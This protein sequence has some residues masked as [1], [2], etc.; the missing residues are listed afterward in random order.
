MQEKCYFLISTAFRFLI[1]LQTFIWTLVLACMGGQNGN[2]QARVDLIHWWTGNSSVV[3]PSN[4]H[5]HVQHSCTR[6]S[7]WECLP[8]VCVLLVCSHHWLSNREEQYENSTAMQYSMPCIFSLLW[9]TAVGLY[10]YIYIYHKL[11]PS[12]LANGTRTKLKS[13]Y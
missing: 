13:T 6:F 1:S 2:M 3:I 7:S 12:M 5:H 10:I 11:R 8:H 9:I 4:I